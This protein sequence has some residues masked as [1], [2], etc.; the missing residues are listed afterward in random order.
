MGHARAER[1]TRGAWMVWLDGIGCALVIW[2]VAAFLVSGLREPDVT[3]MRRLLSA[4]KVLTFQR[5]HAAP[6][7]SEVK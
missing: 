5:I 1:S 2:W 4:G 6:D 3:S 7:S